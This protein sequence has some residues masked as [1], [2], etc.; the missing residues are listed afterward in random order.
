M[1][2]RIKSDEEIEKNYLYHDKDYEYAKR[3]LITNNHKYP[4]EEVWIYVEESIPHLEILEHY[5]DIELL[6]VFVI[7][8]NALLSALYVSYD[9]QDHAS[10]YSDG[11]TYIL[12]EPQ[13]MGVINLESLLPKEFTVDMENNRSNQLDIVLDKIDFVLD[14][15]NYEGEIF[16]G[17]LF[18]KTIKPANISRL[19]KMLKLLDIVQKVC[20]AMHPVLC[21]N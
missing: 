12:E 20:R 14:E 17:C 19:E 2:Y 6:D 13:F 21:P 3:D 10:L 5:I 16:N 9:A 7:T 11:T 18:I 4:Q 15:T 1:P 8:E